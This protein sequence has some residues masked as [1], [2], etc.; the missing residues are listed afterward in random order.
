MRVLALMWRTSSL[1]PRGMTR[2]MCLSHSRRESITSR[3]VTSWMAAF[4]TA[5]EDRAEDMAVEMA[6]KDA[7]DSFPPGQP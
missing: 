7:V 3:V 5:V 2:S 6:R 4:G 1:E